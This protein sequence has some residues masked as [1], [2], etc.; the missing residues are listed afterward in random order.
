MENFFHPS[1]SFMFLAL[2]KIIMK[3]AGT[4]KY[5]LVGRVLLS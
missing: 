1:Q 2:A 3:I 5:D 4:E